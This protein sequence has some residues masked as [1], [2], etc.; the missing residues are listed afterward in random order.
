MEQ[1]RLFFRKIGNMGITAKELFY[2]QPKMAEA[3]N[4]A[5]EPYSYAKRTRHRFF[6]RV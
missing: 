6:E 2:P 4:R 3:H 5:Y 1:V